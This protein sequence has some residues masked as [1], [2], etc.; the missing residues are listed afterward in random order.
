[1][2]TFIPKQNEADKKWYVIDAQGKHLGR[3]ASE[4]AKILRGKHKPE[5]TPHLDM[6]D[7]VVIV[8]A[9][10]VELTG[11]KLD[12]S[13]HTYHTGHPGGLKQISFRTMLAEKPD[14]LIL[15]SVKGMLPKNRLGR[16]ML[17]KLKV[18]AGPNHQHQAQQPETL[19]F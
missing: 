17:T 18:Y 8:N 1:M 14:K 7:F 11:K 12:Q 13:F 6:G 5:F 9:E 3:L 10:K 15:N 4:V 2:K 16:Q 19:E